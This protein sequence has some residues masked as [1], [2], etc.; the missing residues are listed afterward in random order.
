MSDTLTAQTKGWPTPR[1]N[2]AEKRGDAAAEDRNGLVGVGKRFSPD[3][4]NGWRTVWP[5]VN[6]MPNRAAGC[7]LVGNAIVPVIAYAIF[8][9]IAQA[10]VAVQAYP[11]E[12]GNG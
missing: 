10:E 11:Q 5:V 4:P 6:G 7:R 9:A 8:A 2:D 1:A 3:A 12:A